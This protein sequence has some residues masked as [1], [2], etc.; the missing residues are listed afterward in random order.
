MFALQARASPAA[1]VRLAAAGGVRPASS[2]AAAPRTTVAGA[3][4]EGD[5]VEEGRRGLVAMATLAAS[6]A[7]GAHLLSFYPP[8]LPVDQAQL[9]TVLARDLAA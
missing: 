3:A 1:G 4:P 6:S 8:P 2:R 9:A 7:P 5:E